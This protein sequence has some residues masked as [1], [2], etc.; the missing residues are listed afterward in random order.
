MTISVLNQMQ[1]LDEQIAPSLA[2]AKQRAH[3]VKRA[4]IDLAALGRARGPAPAATGFRI[5][6]LVNDVNRRGSF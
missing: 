1:M 3:L 4:G 6:L 5:R 2:V